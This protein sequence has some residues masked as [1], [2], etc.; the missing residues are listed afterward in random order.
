MESINTKSECGT[1][2][3]TLFDE[4][5][6]QEDNQELENNQKSLEKVSELSENI[7]NV[8]KIINPLNDEDAEPEKE[9]DSPSATTFTKSTQELEP[10]AAAV[11]KEKKKSSFE[12]GGK[13]IYED[14]EN[15][16]KLSNSLNNIGKQ[17]QNA[18]PEKENDSPSATTF[19]EST[20]ELEPI[21]AA[22]EKEKKKPTSEEGAKRIYEDDENI[23][24]LSNSLNK[25]ICKQTQNAKPEKKQEEHSL[26]TA[27]L[28]TSLQETSQAVQ[29]TTAAVEIGEFG[30]GDSQEVQKI[31]SDVQN[32]ESTLDFGIEKIFKLPKNLWDVDVITKFVTEE[33]CKR[34]KN[35]ALPI[36]MYMAISE[37][38][39]HIF[40]I[41][42]GAAK[43]DFTGIRYLHFKSYYTC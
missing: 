39:L 5:G 42:S 33:V 18:E 13:R 11:E 20:Q 28:E 26:V 15:I 6:L 12:G 43:L 21:A 19:T 38:L 34:T 14:D 36:F 8:D 30:L 16:D 37:G 22:V 3:V 1:S 32:G 10:I 31:I 2:L 24:K 4:L 41:G 29:K 7:I 40:N 17:T 25:D 35:N 23:D 9:N 27:L